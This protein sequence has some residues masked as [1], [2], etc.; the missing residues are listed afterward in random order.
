[1]AP[2]LQRPLI[3]ADRLITSTLPPADAT[4]RLVPWAA[5]MRDEDVRW[6]V[7]G[8]EGVAA[9]MQLVT[10]RKMSF[11][12]ETVFSHWERQPD[13]SYKSKVELIENLQR[14]GYFV[15]LFFV[16]L[17]NV[18]IS[19]ARVRQRRE[20]GGHDVDR[21]KLKARFPRTQKAIGQAAPVADMT[22]MFENS[23]DARR[24]YQVSRVQMKNVVLF[25]CRDPC[26]AVPSDHRLAAS[27]WLEPIVGRFETEPQPPLRSISSIL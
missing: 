12:F 5:R 18:E 11:A 24:A 16:G 6:Q 25:D 27:I 26:Y 19:M 8:Q 20:R 21:E 15:V 3:N 10:S 17:A 7:L 1:M 23:L 13:G 2:V 4:G 22:V 9:F 14:S